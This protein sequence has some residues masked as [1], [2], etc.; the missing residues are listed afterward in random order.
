MKKLLLG[1]SI[2]VFASVTFAD[3]GEDGDWQWWSTNVIGGPIT[4]NIKATLEAEFRI[5]D[6]MGDFYYNHEQIQV[7]FK[8]CDWFSIAPGY[9]QVFEKAGDSWEAEQRPLIDAKVKHSWESGWTISNRARLA[10]RNLS[11]ADDRVRFRNKLTLK[12]PVSWT[13]W[14]IRPYIA[15]EIFVESD[16]EGFNR[17]RLYVG[18]RCDLYGDL[19]GGLFYLWQTSDS[20]DD[21]NDVNVI[22]TQLKLYF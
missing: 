14:N 21:W 8:L 9:R 3:V 7:K 13:S 10:I 1:L 17:N 16:G 5:G 19:K 2:F 22:G 20:G 4:E 11:D 6:D 15:E 18:L 12:F